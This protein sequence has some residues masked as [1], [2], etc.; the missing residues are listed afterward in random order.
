[1]ITLASLLFLVGL[2]LLVASA[3]LLNRLLGLAV[4]GLC[5]LGY[6]IALYRHKQPKATQ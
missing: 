5:F 6:S 3:W 1:M 4:L 2:G